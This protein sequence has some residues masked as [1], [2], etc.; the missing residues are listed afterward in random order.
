M[1]LELIA[2]AALVVAVVSRKAWQRQPGVGVC[3]ERSS[4]D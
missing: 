4:A 3:E 1:I 2:A